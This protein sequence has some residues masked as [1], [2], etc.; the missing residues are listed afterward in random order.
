MIQPIF[1]AHVHPLLPFPQDYLRT[2]GDCRERRAAGAVPGARRGARAEHPV[3]QV[4]EQREWGAKG[5]A[6]G[7]EQSRGAGDGHPAVEA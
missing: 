3:L 7:A 2:V 5:G 6:L 4:Q 1:R